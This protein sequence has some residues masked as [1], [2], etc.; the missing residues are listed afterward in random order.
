MRAGCLN[1]LRRCRLF[2]S[3]GGSLLQDRTS[4]RSLLY[5]LALLSLARRLGART[6]VFAQGIGPL[7]RPRARRLT[8]RVLARTDAIT[9]RDADSAD[10]VREL[11]ASYPKAPEVEVTADPVFALEPKVTERVTH[12]AAQRPAIGIALR[13]WTGIERLLPAL[14]DGLG[15]FEGEVSLQAWAL[16]PSED[17]PVCERLAE[18]LPAVQVLSQPLTPQEWM[19]LAG[20][21]DAVLAMRLHAMIFAAARA[22]PVVGISYDPKV[23]ALLGRLRSR[24]VG[25]VEETA[26][27]AVTAALESALE[28][29]EA[30]RR[31]REARAQHFRMAAERNVDRA[32]ELLDG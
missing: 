22:T 31:D 23:D 10:L 5:Y 24:P 27:E 1:E 28:D 13:P 26:S 6:M 29:T 16:Q 11:L 2:L 15:R 32:L 14:A 7:I 9:V 18:L 19:T 3:G 17:L 30:R 25:T 8:A 21:T 20:W 12:A 4:L